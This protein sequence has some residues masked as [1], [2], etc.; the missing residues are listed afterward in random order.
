MRYDALVGVT[1]AYTIV[2]LGGMSREQ[3]GRDSRFALELL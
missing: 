3:A 1:V 2:T